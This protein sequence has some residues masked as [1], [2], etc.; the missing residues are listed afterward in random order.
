MSVYQ[1]NPLKDPRWQPF[2]DHHPGG[3]IFHSADWLEALRRTYGYEPV[4]YTTTSPGKEL[5]NGIVFCRIHSWVS[6][7]RLVSLPFSDHCEPLAAA[8]DRT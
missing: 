8:L 5:S 4:V 7:S 3:S 1:F 2:V 6:G